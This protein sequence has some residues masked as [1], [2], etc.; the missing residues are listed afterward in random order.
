MTRVT[1]GCVHSATVRYVIKHIRKHKRPQHTSNTG[2]CCPCCAACDTR[3]AALRTVNN[4]KEGLPH[5]ECFQ[6][7]FACCD[8]CC[9]PCRD[10][11]KGSLLCL[12]CETW[13]CPSFS[14]SAT[15]FLLQDAYHIRSDPCDNR[16]IRFNNCIQC[17][18]CFCDILAC[19]NRN[20][21]GCAQLLDCIACSVWHTL[22][23]CMTGQVF[24]ELEY[25]SATSSSA[26]N[27][28]GDDADVSTPLVSEKD[29]NITG[30]TSTTATTTATTVTASV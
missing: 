24:E 9:Q 12:A 11:S 5:Y 14:I 16:I 29:E 23:G 22:M 7:Y 20:F 13:C 10:A 4:V 8:E 19:F 2:F 6:G 17:L 30:T 25:R 21:E 15:R 28:A 26:S 3:L 1:R 27:S 18:S